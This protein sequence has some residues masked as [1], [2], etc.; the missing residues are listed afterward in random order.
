[1]NIIKYIGQKA[2]KISKGAKSLGAR[3]AL[4]GALTFGGCDW[5]E[6]YG[7]DF[8]NF[9]YPSPYSGL[10]LEEVVSTIDTPREA[11]NF[12][13]YE[14]DYAY[15]DLSG[16]PEPLNRAQCQS[17]RKTFERKKGICRDGSIAVAA[18]LQ[19]DGF[20]SY[21]LSAEFDINTGK[22][23]G[24]SVFVYQDKNGKWGSAGINSSDFRH[25]LYD[26]LED[27]ARDIAG[28]YDEIYRGF[29]LY[30]LSL[31]D[32]VEGT[33]PGFVRNNPFC[34]KIERDYSTL[35][36]S[37]SKKGDKYEV[38][39]EENTPDST[40]IK[41]ALYT[42]DVFDDYFHQEQ[43][44][45][46]CGSEPTFTLEWTVLQRAPFRLPTETNM[47]MTANL[48]ESEV[49]ESNEHSNIVYNELKKKESEEVEVERYRNGE[50]TWYAI[51]SKT[52]HPNEIPSTITEY[53]SVDGD[54][55]F[56]KIVYVECDSNGTLISSETEWLE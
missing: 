43:W 55:E 23:S 51:Q 25:P 38:S 46:P 29:R 12:M 54:R 53:I 36:G 47:N 56:D 2:N 17:F 3:I 14:I 13:N 39:Y 6:F 33:N 40:I 10:T 41:T 7:S 9:L 35:T 16:R 44:V 34:I 22:W 37:V 50:L 52:F 30:D 11:Q 32:L 24:H 19:D 18:M 4:I 42:E 15:G 27:I 1:M 5:S 20:P 45:E 49:S 31:L 48:N 28:D 21:T 26:S 8:Y